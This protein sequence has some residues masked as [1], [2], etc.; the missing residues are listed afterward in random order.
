MKNNKLVR[1]L[2]QCTIYAVAAIMIVVL[3]NFLVDASSTI[4]PKYTKMAQLALEGNTVAVPENYN[5]RA[6]QVC[7]VEEM[8]DVPETIVIGSS[9]GMFLGEEITGLSNI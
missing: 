1:F 7:I 6:Y 2:L 8:K 3:I 9:R 4:R 5:E